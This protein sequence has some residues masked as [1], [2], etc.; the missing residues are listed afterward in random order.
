ML[1]EI[2]PAKASPVPLPPPPQNSIDYMKTG[3]EVLAS[4]AG[5]KLLP[6]EQSTTKRTPK[7]DEKQIPAEVRKF[8]LPLPLNGNIYTKS[9]AVNVAKQY[10]KKTRE[11]GLAVEA[12]IS[13]GYVPAGV[14]TMNRLLE[15]DEKGTP[16]FDT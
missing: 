12:M 4:A 7:L 1:G 13:R 15:Q 11:R 8:P 14:R 10:K 5:S 3:I 16:I 9:E 6:K 2:S